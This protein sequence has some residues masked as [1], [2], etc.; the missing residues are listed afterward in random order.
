[1]LRHDEFDRTGGGTMLVADRCAPD[2]RHAACEVRDVLNR[3]GDKWSV[4]VVTE[5][6]GGARRRGDVGAGPLGHHRRRLNGR[7]RII[8]GRNG[9]RR[10]L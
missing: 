2:L 3:I 9:F 5:L 8:H 1:M 4:P 10:E 7:G 6:I